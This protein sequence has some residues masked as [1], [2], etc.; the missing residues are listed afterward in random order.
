[1]IQIGYK[2]YEYDCY[3]DDMLIIVKAIIGVN[4]MKALLS[5]EFDMK[6]LGVAKKLFRMEIN[7]DKALGRLWLSRS[8]YAGKVLERFSMEN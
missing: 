1:M 5:R 6:E 7:R 2:R 4:K 8:G 3:V